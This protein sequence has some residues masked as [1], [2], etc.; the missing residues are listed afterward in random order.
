[1]FSKQN[2]FPKK[3]N[4]GE[5]KAEKTYEQTWKLYKSSGYYAVS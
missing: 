1:M 3:Q 5:E 4:M 2:Y